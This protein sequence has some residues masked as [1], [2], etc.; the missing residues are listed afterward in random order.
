[1]LGLVKFLLLENANLHF[2]ISSFVFTPEF[3]FSQENG[4]IPLVEFHGITGKKNNPYFVALW[5]SSVDC[6]EKI[7]VLGFGFA[8]PT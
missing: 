4:S 6:V 5:V 8:T 2:L 3:S 1:M 7:D